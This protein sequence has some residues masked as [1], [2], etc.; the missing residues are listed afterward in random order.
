MNRVNSFLLGM[1]AGAALL[2]VA[3]HYHI[4][5]GKDGLFVVP[6]VHNNLSDFYVDTRQFALRD[7]QQHRMLAVA[8]MQA[9]REDVLQDS[10]LDDFRSHVQEFISGWLHHDARR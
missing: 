7:W 3:M 4:V 10:A 1:V 9:Q 5:H 6:K 2:G 8:I